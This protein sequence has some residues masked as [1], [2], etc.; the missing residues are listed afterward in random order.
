MKLTRIGRRSDGLRHVLWFGEPWES[1]CLSTQVTGWPVKDRGSSSL[2]LE[3]LVG[4]EDNDVA[5]Q[6]SL[7]PWFAH[8][9]LERALPRE[10]RQRAYE[11]V[12]RAAEQQKMSGYQ[13]DPLGGRHTGLRFFDGSLWWDLWTNGDWSD[14]DLKKPPW[15]GNGWGGS[16]NVE[17][18][19]FGR[20]K[21]EGG[22]V[23]VD[24][25]AKV[26]MPEGAYPAK[27]TIKQVR[28]VRK[29]LPWTKRWL[30]RGSVEV[31]GGVPVPGKGSASYNCGDDATYSITF[32]ADDEL[33]SE[34]VYLRKF[35][36]SVLESRIRR[37]GAGWRPADGW[38][39]HCEMNE[40][41]TQ[42]TPEERGRRIVWLKK[43]PWEGDPEKGLSDK[44][45]PVLR[46]IRKHGRDTFDSWA[47]AHRVL[48]DPLY[49]SREGFIGGVLNL[50]RR[51]LVR[52]GTY[53]DGRVVFEPLA[54]MCAIAKGV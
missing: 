16:Y 20:T 45:V 24:A 1:P 22:E 43:G 26:Q 11:W 53:A 40:G 2:G 34:Y 54:Q 39:D 9:G 13:L 49:K 27:V 30:Y 18:A 19:L 14:D 7:G 4:G 12:K 23:I 38:P 31:E 35:T 37:G 52:V 17:A 36:K 29:R 33:L 28:W 32:G 5:V 44:Q 50:S 51:G 21:Y 42:R 3:L 25:E 46:Q 8:I 15:L 48:G 47:E 41:V 6:L 10:V